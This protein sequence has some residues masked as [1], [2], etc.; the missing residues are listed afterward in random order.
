M[1]VLLALQAARADDGEAGTN[2]RR[3]LKSCHS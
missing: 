3:I 1:V 2:G